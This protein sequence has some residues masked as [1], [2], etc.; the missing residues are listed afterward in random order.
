[1][2][3]VQPPP[4][5]VALPQALVDRAVAAA[6][7]EARRTGVTGAAVTPFLLATVERM[8]EG[9]SLRANL[10]L[11]EENAALAGRIAVALASQDKGGVGDP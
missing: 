10:G 9:R 6:L 1:V 4:A 11:L 8:T 7:A 5:D 3:V 2:L